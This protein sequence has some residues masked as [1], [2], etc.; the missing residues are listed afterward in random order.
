MKFYRLMFLVSVSLF[1]KS[2]AQNIVPSKS[3]C[4]LQE[5]V[6]KNLYCHNCAKYLEF[7]SETKQPKNLDRY[8]R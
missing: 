6:N 7:D 5:K 1:F 8:I 2:T 3:D 4:T